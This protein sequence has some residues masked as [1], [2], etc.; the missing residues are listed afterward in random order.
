MSL[1]V[2]A[3]FYSE[4]VTAYCSSPSNT[5]SVSSASSLPALGVDQV[6]PLVLTNAATE[7]VFEIVYVTAVSGTTLT[8]LRAQEGTIAQNWQVNDLIS[9]DPTAASVGVS[10]ISPAT[11]SSQPVPLGQAL[12]VVAVTA[13]GNITLGNVLKTL[14]SAGGAT[15]AITLTLEPGTVVGQEV[16]FR[17][18]AYGYTVQS[19]VTTGAP[20]FLF[21]DG[22]G[23]YSWALPAGQS[24]VT[25]QWDGTNWHCQTT[26]QVVVAPATGANQ[27]VNLG[28]TPTK[29]TT[30][31][32]VTSS[33]HGGVLYT[34]SNTTNLYVWI[35][36]GSNT[37]S[38]SSLSVSLNGSAYIT[39]AEDSNS[40]GGNYAT[41]M[42]IVPPGWT[43]EVSAPYGFTSWVE[44]S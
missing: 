41:G 4:Y 29:N 17:S 24:T 22:T 38:T 32:N 19:N 8:I 40:N 11:T 34:N 18:N 21:A 10:N 16:T 42:F 33:R 31:T 27:A 15:A 36:S 12:N 35:N 13:T 14:V 25:L 39:F 28:Q 3:N 7:S 43:Y 9:C 44:L 2:F 6:I 5:I 26:G 23:V 37:Y 1:F 30:V 20:E